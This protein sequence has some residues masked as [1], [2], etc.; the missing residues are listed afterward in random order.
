MAK[1]STKVIYELAANA[2]KIKDHKENREYVIW[3]LK[4]SHVAKCVVK[5]LDDS[6]ETEMYKSTILSNFYKHVGDYSNDMDVK[7][8]FRSI[9]IDDSPKGEDKHPIYK[10]IYKRWITLK[11]KIKIH[12]NQI[13]FIQN[14][15]DY[16]DENWLRYSTFKEWLLSIEGWEF[17][18]VRGEV[19]LGKK[20][21]DPDTCCY[22]SAYLKDKTE[23]T[24]N[25]LETVASSYIQ[26]TD[27]IFCLVHPD[28]FIQISEDEIS[29]NDYVVYMA[30]HNGMVMYVGSGKKDRPKHLNSGSSHNE[31]LNQLKFKVK[32][33][34]Y[35]VIFKTAN[36]KESL[37]KEKEIIDLTRPLCNKM[38]NEGSNKELASQIIK[39][40]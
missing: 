9:F 17:L 31:L 12:N 26:R 34:Q 20:I 4:S 21:Y 3:S 25:P 6:S 27:K 13:D 28:N 23:L 7:G 5:Y 15:T 38:M 35:K 39:L 11:S 19:I 32:N 22:N 1:N 16:I 10:K 36:R 40:L 18:Q 8:A 24:Q 14:P 37:D 29:E 2:T 30:Y 33:I